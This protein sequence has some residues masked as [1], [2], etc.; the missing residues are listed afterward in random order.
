MNENEISF[1]EQIAGDMVIAEEGTI[2]GRTK[3]AISG[4]T[5]ELGAAEVN[6]PP[7]EKGQ[8]IWDGTY[9]V[10]LDRGLTINSVYE[11]SD[12]GYAAQNQRVY[13]WGDRVIVTWLTRKGT[14]DPLPVILSGGS[15]ADF[16]N[17][18]L[19]GNGHLLDPGE[20][21]VRSAMAAQPGAGSDQ[22]FGDN[23]FDNPN[24]AP[25]PDNSSVFDENSSRVVRLPGGETFYDKFGRVVML[26]RNPNNEFLVTNGKVDTGQDDVSD[27][28]TV[29]Q[30]DSYYDGISNDESSPVNEEEPFA[31][32]RLNTVQY[33]QTVKSFKVVGDVD[34]SRSVRR[35]ILPRFD[36]WKFNPIVIR[37]YQA[38]SDG[39][40]ESGTIYS[41]KQQRARTI[42]SSEGNVYGYV[43]TV[44]DQG[45]VKEFVPRHVNQRI[46]KDRLQ[47]IGGND[48]LKIKTTD[49][50]SDGSSN[51][52]NWVH[53]EYLADGTCRLRVNENVTEGRATFD[54]KVSPDGTYELYIKAGGGNS[55]DNNTAIKY[56]PDGSI[57]IKT[58]QKIVIDSEADIFVGGESGAEPIPLGDQL[59]AY[60]DSL[61][62]DV[63]RTWVPVP[64]DGGTALKTLF[65][66]WDAAHLTDDYLSDSRKVNN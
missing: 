23:Q 13:N 34:E 18:Q 65:S 55:S 27:L 16:Y 54:Q 39:E 53:R 63:F 21:I 61:L 47:S 57:D 3:I 20:R 6:G 35:G 31:P 25:T 66:A 41:I 36:K 24:S 52:Q 38:D 11:M 43:R 44:T 22:P 28:T 32:K 58:K 2:R 45:D 56:L 14:Q 12:F 19:L 26:S 50:L 46:V 49:R 33:L 37:K 51:P 17:K 1:E 15:T 30:Q 10:E 29:A 7:G 5:E 64:T 42:T 62:A 59:K 60:I 8:N 48:E 40:V 4:L 9:V